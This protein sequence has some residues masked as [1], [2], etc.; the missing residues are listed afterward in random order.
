MAYAEF[1]GHAA[2]AVAAGYVQPCTY[3]STRGGER[4]LPFERV[5]LAAYAADGGLFVP[6][7]LPHVSTATLRSWAPLSMAQVCARVMALFTDLE[8][9]TC[10][11]LASAAFASFNG[12]R[13]PP[14]PLRDVGGFTLLDTGLGPTLAFKDIGQQ[15]VAQLLDHYLGRRGAHANVVVE[16][17]GDTGPAAIAGVA[18]CAH[19]SIHCLYPHGRVSDVQELQMVTVDAPNVFVYR[20]EGNTDEQAEAL[21]TVFTD[22]AFMKRH[23]VVSINSINWARVMVQASYYVWAS[24][25]LRPNAD[26]PVNFVV[27]S[28][29]FGNACGGL[30][31]KLIGAPVGTIACATNANDIVA[32]TI[33]TGDMSQAANIPTLS[34][35]MDIQFAYNL[36]RCLFLASG[37]DTA[38]V[39]AHM[40]PAERGEAVRLAPPLLAAVRRTFVSCAVS[41]EETL[42]T[43][44]RMWRRCAVALCPHS[45]V[46]VHAFERDAAVRAAC[47]GAPTIC[48]LTAHPAK[49]GDAVAA[50]GLPPQSTP[51]VDALRKLPHRFEWLRAPPGADAT[52]KRAAWA[53]FVKEAVVRR[54]P[55]RARL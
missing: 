51:E 42:A 34:P 23:N 28:G 50:A 38:A 53:A 1:D 16:T 32:R 54:E 29:A 17:S 10:E 4:G 7:T 18:G 47:A 43:M 33:A 48:V 9:P 26:G 3:C 6:E 15:V 30:V 40:L 8:L 12:G 44:R 37:G 13:E 25:Q 41:D 52:A 27:P 22:A 39:R 14:L 21:K 36:E 11:R 5:L 2:V 49:F 35:A 19:V 20:T 45:A 46:G 24:L 31:A 55:K